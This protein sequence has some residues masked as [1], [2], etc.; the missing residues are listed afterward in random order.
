MVYY[1]SLLQQEAGWLEE[2]AF[3]ALE[4]PEERIRYCILK[5]LDQ[6]ALHRS[7]L[8]GVFRKALDPKS[9]LS[10]FSTETREIREDNIALFTRVLEESRHSFHDDF[11][12]VLPRVIWL[13]QMGIIL[14]WFYDRSP[15]QTRSRFLLEISLLLFLRALETLGLP[16]MGGFRRSVLTLIQTF[17]QIMEEPAN[18][19]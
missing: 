1:R 6:L 13:Y 15:G 17:D 9:P 11:K 3:Q 12:P 4:K 10:P 7:A 2:P 16:L 19:P 8:E 18:A 14:A 5:K